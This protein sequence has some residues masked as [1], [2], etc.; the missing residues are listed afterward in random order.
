MWKL[1]IGILKFEA[2]DRKENQE[3][4]LQFNLAAVFLKRRKV[5]PDFPPH[6]SA[7]FVAKL[8]LFFSDF[9]CSNGGSG[10]PAGARHWPCQIIRPQ[11]W[12]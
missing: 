12:V 3:S 4:F 8:G 5:F 9:G 6:G 2:Q 11:I 10:D 7:R 1:H